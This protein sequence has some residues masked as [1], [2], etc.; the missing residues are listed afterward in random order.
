MKNFKEYL[1]EKKNFLVRHLIQKENQK[2]WDMTDKELD[3][4]GYKAS[5][6]YMNDPFSK[7]GRVWQDQ[8]IDV[9]TVKYWKRIYRKTL[10]KHYQHS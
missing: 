2:F 4:V 5:N 3:R 10:R 9:A 6:G 8:L 1:S 7:Q